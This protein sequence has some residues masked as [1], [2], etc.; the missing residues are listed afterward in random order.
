MNLF[1]LF[2]LWCRSNLDSMTGMTDLNWNITYLKSNP[3]CDRIT[4]LQIVSAGYCAQINYL[5]SNPS[6][7]RITILQIV[8]AGYYAQINYLKSNPSCDRITILQIVSAG[9]CAQINY[10]VN[11]LTGTAWILFVW[12][13][14]IGD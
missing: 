4:I 14:I 7:D 13:G 8:S 1:A 9:Y 11:I 6:C 5:K 3:S 2:A 10:E 12:T